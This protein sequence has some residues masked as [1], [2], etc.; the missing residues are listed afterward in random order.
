M[1]PNRIIKHASA[2]NPL[3]VWR[4][5]GGS[6]PFTSGIDNKIVITVYHKSGTVLLKKLFSHIA[7]VSGMKIDFRDDYKFSPS[8][9]IL[10]LQHTRVS[11]P[12]L[13][14]YRGCHM[15][16]DPRDIIVSSYN[17]HLVSD[18]RWL[19]KPQERYEGKSYAEY[20]AGFDKESGINI[21]A[22]RFYSKAWRHMIAWDY[23][24]PDVFE[25]RYEAMI[26]DPQHQFH[27]LLEF[28]NFKPG[29]IQAA[30]KF[31]ERQSLHRQKN[32]K[33]VLSGQ[34]GNWVNHVTENN[35]EHMKRLIG[36]GLIQLGY[37][38]T[39]DWS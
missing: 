24:N 17:Y 13:D 26:L 36:P 32:S 8:I 34:P 21:E 20:L 38:E 9:E 12:P 5:L 35:I 23:G 16:R 11:S 3:R 14:D 37:E 29:V 2:W 1:D 25:V 19:H 7:L 22:D 30:L 33:H 39:M 27:Q 18:E 4:K 6:S 31:L 10:F 28:L 15:I